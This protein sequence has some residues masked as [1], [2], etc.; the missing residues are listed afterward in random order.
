MEFK[1][2]E[3]QLNVQKMVARFAHEEITPQAVLRDE[4]AIFDHKLYDRICELGI[5]GLP[6]SEQYGGSNAGY[7]AYVLACEQICL[8]DDALGCGVAVN[9]GLFG[10]ALDTFGTEA[11]KQKWLAPVIQDK[12]IGAFALT[13]PNAGSDAAMQKSSARL[14]GDDYVLS[15]S[16]IFITSG[17]EADFY[18]VFAMTDRS[19]GL[20]GISAFLLQNGTAG[21]RFGRV[22]KKLG[23]HASTTRELIFQDVRIPKENLLGKEGDGFKIAMSTLDGGRI[24]V[25]AQ[26]LALAASAFNHASNYCKQR[27]QFNRPV[28]ANQAIQFMLADM[29]TAIEASRLLIYRAAWLKENKLP[30]G[31]EAAMAKLY[32]TDTAMKVTIDAVQLFGGRGYLSDYPVER[33]MRNAKITQIYEGTNQIQRMV[34]ASYILK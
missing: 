16:K 29:A 2:T 28:A 8:A 27:K 5:C 4:G 7:L 33:L 11:Q 32:A 30:F 31:K 25:A 34:I 17:G 19:Q 24:T 6:F 12:K 10:G 9:I 15:G 14:V 20:R 22:E 21:F 23:I 13:E 26:G 18:L 1:L 3:K